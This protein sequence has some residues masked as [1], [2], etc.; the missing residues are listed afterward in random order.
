MNSEREFWFRFCCWYFIKNVSLLWRGE[1]LWAFGVT[2][3]DYCNNRR[4]AGKRCLSDVNWVFM[5]Q[6]F[7]IPSHIYKWGAK[8]Y[9]SVQKKNN[10]HFLIVAQ[11]KEREPNNP[12]T[13]QPNKDQI[14]MFQRN[15]K[16]T[17]KSQTHRLFKEIYISD[18]LNLNQRQLK[19]FWSTEA[20]AFYSFN[21]SRCAQKSYLCILIGWMYMKRQCSGEPEK[22]TWSLL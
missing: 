3:N 16:W 1:K 20:P 11:D 18:Q 22:L 17:K 8:Y 2:S 4:F 14:Y 9:I 5:D 15:P 6:H 7:C 12:K 13:Q 21:Q 19:F 10:S